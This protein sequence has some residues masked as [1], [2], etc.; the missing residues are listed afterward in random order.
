MSAAQL[1]DLKW[2]VVASVLHTLVLVN[3]EGAESV[4]VGFRR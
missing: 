4:K 3:V 1:I 2:I